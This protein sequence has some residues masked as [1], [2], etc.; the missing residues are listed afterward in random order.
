[1]RKNHL[2]ALATVMLILG[3]VSVE[4]RPNRWAQN[5]VLDV[6]YASPEKK[7]LL[8]LE[9]LHLAG[10]FSNGVYGHEYTAI[11][12]APL[13]F[14]EFSLA[15]HADGY[16]YDDYNYLIGPIKLSPALKGGYPF[17]LGQKKSFFISPGLVALGDF[18]TSSV[19]LGDSTISPS[20]SP[21]F[22]AKAIVGFGI[23]LVKFNINAGYGMIFDSVGFRANL[24]YGAVLEIS[25]L[26]FLSFACEVTNT[27]PLDSIFS[28]NELIVTPLVRV[29]TAKV[30][31]ATFDVSA[32]IGI[33]SATYPWKIEIGVSAA[34]DL[35]RPP[36]VPRATLAGKVVSEENAE[37]LLATISFP[38][39][40]I[41]GINTDSLTGIFQMELPPGAYRVR[42]E[43]PGY[44]WKEQGIILQ[45]KDTKLLDFALAKIKEPRA[46]VSGVIRDQKTAEPI[47]GVL[48]S[49]GESSIPEVR[50]DALGI[51]KSILPPGSYS[52]S[53]T[54]EGYAVETMEVTLQDGDTRELNVGLGLP[55]P[56][57]VPEFQNILFK[58]GSAEILPESYPAVE[59]VAD[60]LKSY[61]SVRVEIQGHTDSIGDDQMNLDLSQKRADVVREL[62]VKKGIDAS[63]LMARGYGE[64]K[65][66][67]DNR[68]R[69]GQEQNR[70]IEFVIIND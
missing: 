60:F 59:E 16:R 9:F 50:T 41:Q 49:F 40:E 13:S 5:G 43:S 54:K 21:S 20:R 12:F 31:G 6:F 17:F 14:L 70:R 52:L 27:D 33:G 30:G 11:G 69:K 62:L 2:I 64:T 36:K 68:T 34:F 25:P 45:D 3:N 10:G 66:I 29:S 23:D 63:R 42:A 57:E 39:S 58:P 32:P 37:P 55:K 67:G 35:A 26:P 8:T 28:F 46:Q 15:V 51:F 44:K 19:W 18:S 38:G 61:S 22:D 56:Q 65:P 7:G 48:V 53:F 24:P 47:E 4:A 1:M